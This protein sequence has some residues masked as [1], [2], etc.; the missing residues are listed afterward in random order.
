[1]TPAWRRWV[2]RGLKVGLAWRLR[3]RRHR[4]V[5]I[6]VG[7]HHGETTMPFAAARPDLIVYAFEP[8]PVAAHWMM[9]RLRNYVVLPM[10]VALEDGVA[11]FKVAAYEQSSSLLAIDDEVARNWTGGDGKFEILKTNKVPTMRLDTFLDGMKIDKVDFLKVDAQG[12][13]LDVVKSAGARLA[14]VRRV[15]LEVATGG[16][17][18]QGAASRADVIAFMEGSGFRLQSREDES[19]GQEENLTFVNLEEH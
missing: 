14:D 6:D 16:S 1:M 13:D 17:L 3:T 10:A 8:N 12:S 11:E 4:H 5:W 9:G 18:Y 15:Q 2:R 7:A 19:H